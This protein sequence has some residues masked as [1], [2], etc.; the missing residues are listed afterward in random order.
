MIAVNE[1]L[2]SSFW[3]SRYRGGRIYFRSENSVRKE[4][5]FTI[6]QYCG[7]STLQ[8]S[9]ILVGVN[10]RTVANSTEL[11][12]PHLILL[13]HLKVTKPIVFGMGSV[14][15]QQRYGSNFHTRSVSPG[16]ETHVCSPRVRDH[17]NGLFFPGRG[18]GL[19]SLCPD[20]HHCWYRPGQLFSSCH[21]YPCSAYL[22]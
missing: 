18:G 13:R 6:S 17:D 7:E 12:T 15:E 1:L 8:Q 19:L 22:P 16:D 21:L 5:H 14:W 3:F 9:S 10:I 20:V 4:F 11:K 2:L